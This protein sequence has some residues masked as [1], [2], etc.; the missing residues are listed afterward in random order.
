MGIGSAGTFVLFPHDTIQPSADIASPDQIHA[1][2]H[3]FGPIQIDREEVIALA[4]NIQRTLSKGRLIVTFLIASEQSRYLDDFKRLDFTTERAQL[5]RLF[6]R[7]PD[8]TGI[9]KMITIEF[10]QNVNWASVQASDEAWVLGELEKLKRDILRF[11]RNYAARVFGIT[12][13]E[14]LIFVAVILLPSL[15]TT[16]DRAILLGGAILLSRLLDWLRRKYLPHA[17]IHLGKRKE[18]WFQRLLPSAISWLMTLGA[19][20]IGALLIA[21]LKGYLKLP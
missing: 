2:R 21:Y 14:L 15:T 9:D 7:Q 18:G 8:I 19:S 13:N 10:G 1:K 4:D 16:T 12:F 3:D 20:V 17:A 5:V 6:V 11:Q